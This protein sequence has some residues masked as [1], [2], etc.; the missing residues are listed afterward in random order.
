MFGFWTTV[1]LFSYPIT[2]ALSILLY[3]LA[4]TIIPVLNAYIFTTVLRY[5]LGPTAPAVDVKSLSTKVWLRRYKVHALFTVEGFGFGNPPGF[6]HR[7]FAAC[8]EISCH[9]AVSFKD[10][11]ALAVHAWRRKR[12]PVSPAFASVPL[13]FP[14][15][16]TAIE[17]SGKFKLHWKDHYV[18]ICHVY[19]LVIVGAMCNFEIGPGGELSVNGIERTL[20]ESLCQRV[21]GSR[22]PPNRLTVS[23]LKARNLRL[24]KHD[25]RSNKVLGRKKGDPFVSVRAR[26]QEVFTK[27]LMSSTNPMWNETFDLHVKDPSTV[28]TANVWDEDA[29]SSPLIGRWVM[30]TKYLVTDPARCMSGEGF[31]VER[32]PNGNAI[33]GWFP[34]VDENYKN[35]GKVGDIF[36]TVSWVHDPAFDEGYE[37]SPK[38]DAMGQLLLNAEENDYRG[39]DPDGDLLAWKAFPLLFNMRMVVIHEVAFFLKDVFAGYK[40]FKSMDIKNA[41]RMPHIF[42]T[43]SQLE[44]TDNFPGLTLWGAINVLIM[45]GAV[46]QCLANSEFRN[47]AA[48][49]ILSGTIRGFGQ[50]NKWK[51]RRDVMTKMGDNS[52]IHETFAQRLNRKWQLATKGE[53][54]LTKQLT[55]EDEDAVKEPS[56]SG[57]LE[58]TSK[59]SKFPNMFRNWHLVKC[60]VRGSTLYYYPANNG[61]DIN[62]SLPGKNKLKSQARIGA[63]HGAARKL[64][65]D[66][67]KDLKLVGDQGGELVIKS[68]EKD[69]P[70]RYFRLPET[71]IG[72]EDARVGLEFWY[73]TIDHVR[74]SY[75]TR[76]SIDKYDNHK[77]FDSVAAE[78]ELSLLEMQNKLKDEL[79][80]V[81]EDEEYMSSGDEYAKKS[82][83]EGA[84]GDDGASSDELSDKE[85]F[86]NE[87]EEEAMEASALE[88][89]AEFPETSLLRG[90]SESDAVDMKQDNLDER[91]GNRRFSAIGT[92]FLTFST[93]QNAMDR[94]KDMNYHAGLL[95]G[96]SVSMGLMKRQSRGN[97]ER[98]S[99]SESVDLASAK[100]DLTPPLSKRAVVRKGSNGEELLRRFLGKS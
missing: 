22:P 8:E 25:G 80:P 40:G 43:Q 6:P 50:Q 47:S 56:I 58:K 96:A 84:S 55:A 3:S 92:N 64:S 20:A 4:F 1:H 52:A 69:V 83:V 57:Y 15:D 35:A 32:L 78:N 51:R 34:L 93:R 77:R 85:V 79:G 5:K 19:H 95:H 36:L 33:S 65:L 46:P 53:K 28:L 60:E 75:G 67:I 89:D 14:W 39:G 98:A 63:I 10:L 49:S 72:E 42:I 16:P 81:G 90:A 66:N 41:I 27:V 18:G 76:K 31:A 68:F 30:T 94:H 100:N 17:K 24:V 74:R 23:V 9:L 44:P 82:I 54:F 59:P 88:L 2:I 99:S 13:K 26:D 11:R 97:R 91:D 37:P 73:H 48:W 7:Y 61:N 70:T 86:F 87:D 38:P 21:L 12:L 62:P 71:D 45:G 29:F